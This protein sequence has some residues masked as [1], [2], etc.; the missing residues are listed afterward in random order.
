MKK[1]GGDIMALRASI[2]NIGWRMTKKAQWKLA[3]VNQW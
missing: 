1:C 2:A 3:S